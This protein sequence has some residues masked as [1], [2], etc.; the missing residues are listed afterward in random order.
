MH[1]EP[2]TLAIPFYKGL[3]YLRLAIESVRNQSDSSWKL[4]V[5][6]DGPELGVSE[7]V[8]SFADSRIFYSKNPR[9]LGMAGNWNRCIELAP[10]DWVTLLHGDDELL[11]NYVAT[12]RQAISHYPQAAAFFTETQIIDE[13]SKRAFSFVDYIKKFLK[14]NKGEVILEGAQGLEA[15]MHGNFIMC[16]TVCYHKKRLGTDLFS[17]RWKMVLD[18]ECYRQ[19]LIRGFKIVG[20]PVVAYAYRRHSANATTEYTASLLRFQE[21][22]ALHNEIAQQCAAWGW[23]TVAR[24]ALH[25]RMILLHILYRFTF[26]LLNGRWGAAQ[27]KIRFLGE[28][29]KENRKILSE[30]RGNSIT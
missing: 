3:P 14:P 26:D 11:P 2:I 24:V 12:I 22:V 25:K 5:C 28:I 29:L 19:I 15:L 13:R 18:L 6:D 7:L 30:W 17:A 8:N 16:P 4:V 10:T 1:T 23:G 27:T 20:L 21:E 9:N